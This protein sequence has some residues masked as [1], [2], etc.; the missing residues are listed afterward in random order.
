MLSP[1]M[2]SADIKSFL[3]NKCLFVKLTKIPVLYK[4]S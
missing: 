1:T 3:K 4:S 2:K